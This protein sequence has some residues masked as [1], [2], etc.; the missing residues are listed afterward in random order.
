[1]LTGP[2]KVDGVNEGLSYIVEVYD[3][4]LYAFFCFTYT[5]MLLNMTPRKRDRKTKEIIGSPIK[6]LNI[7]T[8]VI[9]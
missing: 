2:P 9:S 1:M 6:K 8:D 7:F 3:V 5:I 4:L